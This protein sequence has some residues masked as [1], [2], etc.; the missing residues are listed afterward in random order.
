MAISQIGATLLLATS[1]IFSIG[2]IFL[3]AQ[4]LADT[5]KA[6][7]TQ[8]GQAFMNLFRITDS[9]TFSLAIGAFCLAG[10]VV[11]NAVSL[12][13]VWWN[14]YFGNV[15]SSNVSV[16]LLKSYLEQPW[17]FFVNSNS[18]AL[19]RNLLVEPSFVIGKYLVSA[20]G[21]AAD[22]LFMMALVCT[23][24]VYDVAVTLSLLAALGI[25]YLIIYYALRNW[26]AKLGKIRL[27]QDELRFRVASENFNGVREIRVF[28]KENFFVSQ[29]RRASDNLFRSIVVR[30]TLR[31]LP[32]HVLETLAFGGATATVLVLLS[33]NTDG[34]SLAGL[35]ALYGMTGYRL[36]PVLDRII[37]QLTDL[38][39]TEQSIDTLVT[40]LRARTGR[41][42][43]PARPQSQ[44]ENPTF[45]QL[46]LKDVLFRYEGAETP[47]LEKVSLTIRHGEAVAFV[48]TT[49]AGKTTLLSLILGLLEPTAGSILVNGEPL[50]PENRAHWR[51]MIGYVP[52]DNFLLDATIAQNIAFGVSDG[53]IDH[54]AVKRAAE[55]ANIADFIETGLPLKYETIVGER[56][57]RLSGGQKQRLAI[58]RA[59]Y[60]D[61][62]VLI[63]DEATSSL[64]TVT[65]RIVAEAIEALAVKKTVIVVAHRL[66]TIRRCDRI[67]LLENGRL[68]VSGSY[69]DLV[70]KSSSFRTMSEVEPQSRQTQD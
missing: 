39:Y 2:S 66:S 16:R 54:E 53:K 48:G 30:T 70:D 5:E 19:K 21:I 6:I 35:I 29:F 58:A 67:Y 61:P 13:V 9:T 17:L 4:V 11:R 40:Q 51:S 59:L 25:P 10:I 57:I 64:D 7:N 65:E 49:G 44:D 3:F 23:L 69:D 8:T 55:M 20:L 33:S 43:A 47:S 27:E 26:N 46:E 24:L 38:K 34:P 68:A 15:V 56:G 22:S 14:A 37:A 36:M 60:R 28:G 12:L 50:S 1:E 18:A 63:L 42:D 31:V 52:Q 41:L 32:R 62:A 45:S